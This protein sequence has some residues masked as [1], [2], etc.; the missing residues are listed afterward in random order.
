M[1][2]SK[3]IPFPLYPVPLLQPPVD[4]LLLAGTARAE[5][6][7]EVE[8]DED[9][10]AKAEDLISLGEEAMTVDAELAE[11]SAASKS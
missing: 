9:L 8:A 2:T 4:F 11:A 1:T 3:T 5:A 6:G 10:E 7:L